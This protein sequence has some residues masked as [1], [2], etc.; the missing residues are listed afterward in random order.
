MTNLVGS[1][2]SQVVGGSA[3]TGDRAE[4]DR[5]TVV[6]K[7]IGVV[8]VREIAV[9]EKT[10]GETQEV[11]VESLVVTLAESLLHGGLVTVLEPTFVGGTVR[12]KKVE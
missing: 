7:V 12:S 10:T 4:K 8:G 5:A 11:Y 1:G 6:Q 9:S 3:S 2:E